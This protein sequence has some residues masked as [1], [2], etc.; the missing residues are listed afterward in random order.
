MARLLLACD[1]TL[2]FRAAAS[3]NARSFRLVAV[4]SAAAPR[5]P[6]RDDQQKRHSA[7][8][9]ASAAEARRPRER[10]P[11]RRG[12]EHSRCR[13]EAIGSARVGEASRF[14]DGQPRLLRV[15]GYQDNPILAEQLAY[16]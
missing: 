8:P 15:P 1:W 14:A 3:T 9:V 12:L 7:G 16:Y 5:A 11:D 13:Y 6:A 10:A 2:R 4:V